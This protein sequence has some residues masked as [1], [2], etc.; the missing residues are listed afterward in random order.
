[1]SQ[2]RG[3][4]DWITMKALEK[5]RTRRYDTAIDLAADVRR[6]LRDEPVLA[7]PPSTVYR[8]TKFVRRHRFG[9]SA[10]A[11]IFLLVVG[12]AVAMA[13][14]ARRVTRER[15]RATQES[16]RANREAEAARQ[17]SDFFLR[18]F[19][20]ADPSEARGSSVTAREILETGSARIEQDLGEQPVL[21]SRV[22]TTIGDA[23]QKLGLYKNADALFRKSL[24]VRT[25]AGVAQDVVAE[26]LFKLGYLQVKSGN[27]NEAAAN[28]GKALAIQESTPGVSPVVV[29]E[30]I[31][32]LGELAYSQGD[33]P[34]AESH[35]GRRLDML[36]QQSPNSEREIADSLTELAMAVQQTRS[37]YAR[38]KALNE[39]ALAIRRRI[40]S[41]PHV[42][43]SESLNN[44]AMVYY[45]SKDYTAAEP[46]FKE[47]LAMNR[48]LFGD[49]HPEVSANLN[50]LGLVARDRG[51]YRQADEL[52]GQAVAMDRTLYGARHIQVARLL[53]NWGETVRRS[54]DPRRAETL[55]RESW[56]IHKEVLSPTHWQAV[57]TEMLIVRC[58]VDQRQF[59]GRGA[60]AQ[61]GVPAD[62]AGVRSDACAHAHRSRTRGG[63]LYGVEEAGPSGGVASQTQ[64]ATDVD[65]H[66]VRWNR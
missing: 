55:L 59:R 58:L 60:A 40:F 24:D 32:A 20:L 38:A 4:L 33:Y 51:D 1:M 53:N 35:F 6:H 15:D 36:R 49:V 18:L 13:G 34:K 27:F 61:R 56:A 16:A 39:E 19:E 28:L 10:A 41:A 26:G 45:R 14:Q 57:A 66:A 30:T 17:V 44:L 3:D 37:D 64:A 12:F 63:A 47:S 29:A 5:D 9:V 54:G 50:N 42:G 46:L 7:G 48:L 62:R 8:A 65:R 2:L 43:I 22:M 31:G 21:Q 25:K 23:Y 52:L 11:A